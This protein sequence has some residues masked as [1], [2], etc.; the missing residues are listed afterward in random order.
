[1]NKNKDIL[2][3]PIV[4]KPKNRTTFINSKI[5]VEEICNLTCFTVA[6]FIRSFLKRGHGITPCS[7]TSKAAGS[8]FFC[9]W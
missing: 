8:Y 1:M 5:E 6:E 4:N 2:V 3:N 9:H 7:H